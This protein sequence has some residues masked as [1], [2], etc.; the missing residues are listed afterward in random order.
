[1]YQD[2]EQMEFNEEEENEKERLK[3][4]EMKKQP[5]LVLNMPSYS[6]EEDKE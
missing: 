1:M 4:I 5:Y 3:A 6:D 2:E